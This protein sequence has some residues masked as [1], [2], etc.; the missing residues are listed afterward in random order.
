VVGRSVEFTALAEFL[1]VA[2]EQPSGLVIEGEAGIGKTT[3]WLAAAGLARE[4]GFRVLGAQAG[5]AE[6]ALAYA[7]LADLIGE[8]DDTV[9]AELT[10]VQ[11]F[12]VDRVLLR[13]GPEGPA[14]DQR[15]A[16]AA[17]LAV[18]EALAVDTPVLVAIDDIQWLDASSRGAVE[19][20]A[21]RFKGRVGVLAAERTEH[22]IGMANTAHNTAW[23]QLSRPDG[24]RRTRVRPLSLGALHALLVEKLG[25][26]FPR[27]TMARIAEISGG[28]PFYALELARTMDGQPSGEPVLPASLTELVLTRIGHLTPGARHVLLAAACAAT[29][30]VELVANATATP[31]AHTVDL[32]EEPEADGIVVIDGN[33]VRFCHPLLA[34]GVYTDASQA[35]RRRMHRALA[36]VVDHPELKARHL[37]LATTSA[38]PATLQALDVAAEVARAR[39]APAAAAEFVDLAMR[40]GGDSPARR[41]RAAEHHFRAGDADR[42]TALLDEHTLNGLPPGALRVAAL[43]IRAGIAF[44]DTG[45]EEAAE[46]LK[47]AVVAAEDHPWLLVT[48]LLFLSLAQFNSGD[49]GEAWSNVERAVA[50]AERLGVAALTSQALA[51]SAVVGYHCGRGVDEPGLRRAL[52]LEDQSLDVPIF[53]NASTN[54][55]LLLGWS[56]RLPEAHAQII[57]VRRRYA[58]RGADAEMMLVAVHGARI[59]TWWG[60]LDDAALDAQEAI[61]RA[62][63]LG[64]GHMIALAFTMR[65]AVA[66]YAGREQDA[67]SDA[68]T[69]IDA[70]ERCASIRAAESTIE[71]LAFLELSLGNYDAAWI[72][73]QP[74]VCGFD[75]LPVME[76]PRAEF[77]PYAVEALIGLGRHGEAEPMIA[78]L[79][80]DGRRLDRP[81]MLAVG[82]RCRSMWLVADGDVEAAE[83]VA[84]QALIEHERLPMPF[85]RARTQLLLGQ[86]QRR[87]RKKQAAEATL[88]EV[89]RAF[90]DIGTPLWADRARAELTRT[91]VGP[92][93]DLLL[94]PSERRVAELA[95]TGMTNRDVAATLFISPKTVEHNL[96]RVYR[97]LGI[98]SRAELGRRIDE[99]NIREIP[100]SSALPQQ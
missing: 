10:E 97:K 44:Y 70:V 53:L 11:R 58:E 77:V 35:S 28:N 22:D 5:Q 99:L 91:N 18:V 6:S 66:A 12:A 49:P 23:L 52:D 13:A 80:R 90:E 74:L 38:D 39:G 75:A 57:Q 81:W 45:F 69:A 59:N 88:T 51:V 96:G 2:A 50:E 26:S 7:A 84:Q 8:V 32:L 62:E 3:L 31:V 79:E 87:L 46:L 24:V 72:T 82:A 71:T 98:R 20:A 27:P 43:V 41:V 16:S 63:Q 19:F 30:T 67:R 83:H 65:A 40:L 61:E 94:T 100:D 36:D 76:F 29:P 17:F 64:G 15:V 86:L 54:N 21:R 1:T 73:L 34:R 93:H 33:R 25:R 9:L 48:A 78:A 92:G 56:G 89:L 4:G 68:Q 14:T 85:E 55:A 37:A 95:A 60:R 42:A 47:P